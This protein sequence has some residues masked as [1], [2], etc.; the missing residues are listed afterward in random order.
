MFRFLIIIFLISISVFPLAS[1][2]QMDRVTKGNVNWGVKVGMNAI[3]SNHCDIFY[4]DEKTGDNESVKSKVGFTTGAFIRINLDN[5]FF[6]PDFGFTNS[7]E[8]LSFLIPLD[9]SNSYRYNI[10]C[11]YYSFDVA[12]MLGY[13]VVKEGPYLL[14]FFVGPTLRYQY[15][16]N[17][18]INNTRISNDHKNNYKLNGIMGLS[19][20]ITNLYFEAKYEMNFSDY[21]IDFNQMSILPSDL[22][23]INISKNENLLSFSCG[24]IF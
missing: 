20:N 24:L 5:F 9:E 3:A 6:Q 18:D 7:R 14:N 19:F 12:T 23:N 16:S 10:N 17:Y 15:K 22:R 4:N 13:N 21:H 1:Q 11:N 2:P 8:K